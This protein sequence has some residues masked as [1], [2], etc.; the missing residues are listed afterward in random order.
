VT[1]L[2]VLTADEAAPD[3]L[4]AA[5]A[6][7]LR[8]FPDGFSDDDW[9]HAQGGWHVL[10][11]DRTAVV[12][13]A[14]LVIRQ[15]TVG[16]RP[17]RTGYVEAVATEPARQ[18]Q[19]LGSL[20]MAE[21]GAIVRREAEMGALSTGRHGFY[22]RLGW[23]RWQGPTYVLRDGHPVRTADEDDGV[24]VLRHGP[25]AAVDLAAAIACPQRTGD[26]W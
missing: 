12:A 25:S 19:G 20:V 21:I 22:E 17:F 13:H 8:A 9:E 1:D 10:V 14:A 5:R 2:R 15:L 3:L 4:A 18:G 11:V 7:C 6:L 24:M 23:E 26:D 16:S